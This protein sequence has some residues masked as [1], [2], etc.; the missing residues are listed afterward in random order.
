LFPEFILFYSV[1]LKYLEFAMRRKCSKY[2]ICVIASYSTLIMDN[3]LNVF[4]LII[5]GKLLFSDLTQQ[6][7]TQWLCAGYLVVENQGF[8]QLSNLSSFMQYIIYIE[9][10]GAMSIADTSRLTHQKSASQVRGNTFPVREQ[11]DPTKPGLHT[12]D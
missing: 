7:A 10:N 4:A 2:G 3:N 12:Q 8:F 6:S 9:D 5:R 11:I 1:Q